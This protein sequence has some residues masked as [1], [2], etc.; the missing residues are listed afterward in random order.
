MAMIPTWQPD[1]LRGHSL[2]AKTIIIQE[3]IK[4]V[5]VSFS[6]LQ[7]STIRIDYRQSLP[8]NNGFVNKNEIIRNS[9]RQAATPIRMFSNSPANMID[10]RRQTLVIERRP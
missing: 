7:P 3:T 5:P 2:P 8:I 4:P 1:H 6:Y 10:T 9:I